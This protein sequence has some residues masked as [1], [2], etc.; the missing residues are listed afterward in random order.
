MYNSQQ[1][2]QN[3]NSGPS[4]MWYVCHYSTPHREESEMPHIIVIYKTK[5]SAFKY[6]RNLILNAEVFLRR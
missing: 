4:V 6:T 3:E 1:D 2:N 5:Y